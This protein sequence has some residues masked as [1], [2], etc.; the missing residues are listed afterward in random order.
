MLSFGGERLQPPLSPPQ[1]KKK[2]KK[3][4]WIIYLHHD[5]GMLPPL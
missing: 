4:F 1:K 2:K 5:L 3:K